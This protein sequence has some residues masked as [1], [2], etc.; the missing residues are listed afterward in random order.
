MFSYDAAKNELSLTDDLVACPAST[1]DKSANDATDNDRTT[2]ANCDQRGATV[3]SNGDCGSCKNEE[4]KNSVT[5]EAKVTGCHDGVGLCS[6]GGAVGE[7]SS[8]DETR[9][10][11]TS[12]NCQTHCAKC[13]VTRTKSAEE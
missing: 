11:V 7:T 4:V 1:N 2:T 5:G 9:G 6:S 8:C 12:G 10:E 3:A 13:R